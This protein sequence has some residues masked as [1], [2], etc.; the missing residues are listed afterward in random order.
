LAPT[1]FEQSLRPCQRQQGIK[2]EVLRLPCD[3]PGAER[4]QDGMVEARIGEVQ[5]EDV[6]PINAAADGIRGLAIGET[7][8]TLE[9]GSQCQARGRLCGLPTRREE[10]RE[11]RV[12][13]EGAETVGHLHV[14]VPAR[15]RG[16]GNPLGFFRDRISG[17]GM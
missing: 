16:T 1:R 6:L 3:E 17:W 9:D 11:L 7:F 5:A 10:R 8:G 12:V 4:T 2:E 13:V 14:E 15:K